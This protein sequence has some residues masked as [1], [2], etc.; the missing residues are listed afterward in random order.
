[1]KAG[2]SPQ[3]S[4]PANLDDHIFEL[5]ASAADSEMIASL[6][7]SA[8]TRRRNRSLAR[9]LREHASRLRQ[10]RCARRIATN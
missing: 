2:T 10:R 6:S 7:D 3:W 5:E 9:R 8:E 4:E 1:M